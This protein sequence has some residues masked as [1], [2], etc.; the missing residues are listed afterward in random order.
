M[1]T[2]FIIGAGAGVDIGMPTG[3]HLKE[4]ISV[5]FSAQDGSIA[6]FPVSI[7]DFRYLLQLLA[8]SNND[9]L[10]NY[11]D[12]GNQIIK[13]L[14]LEI[15]IDNFLHKHYD[16]KYIVAAGKLAIAYSILGFECKSKMFS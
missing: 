8:D 9:Q 10:G 15:S 14:P 6:G 12:A 7:E 16:N 3:F 5:L 4:T 13:G 1:K 11:L 2:I